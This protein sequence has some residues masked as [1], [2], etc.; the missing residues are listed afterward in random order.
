MYLRCGRV[1]ITE[2]LLR[3]T[4]PF[5]RFFVGRFLF[6]PRINY[7][8]QRLA[9]Y[10]TGF[11]I[12]LDLGAGDGKLAARLSEITG[13]QLE[14]CDVVLQPKPRIK[15][16][17][18]DG[19]SLPFDDNSFDCVILVDMLHHVVEQDQLLQEAKRVSRDCILIKDHY[20]ESRLDWAVLVFMDYIGNAPFGID[21]PYRYLTEEEWLEKFACLGCEILK[22][23][24]FRFNPLDPVKHVVYRIQK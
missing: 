24:K 19:T 14:G 7:L 5:L 12:A 3:L 4:H 10:L 1:A 23:E 22:S 15:I 13:C 11:Q 9:K 16:I 17:K 18:Y 21:L 20:W 6:P 8:V 2:K